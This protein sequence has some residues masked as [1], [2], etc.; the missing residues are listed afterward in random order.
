MD[1]GQRKGQYS[2]AVSAP[3]RFRVPQQLTGTVAARTTLP[4]A[5]PPNPE[6]EFLT[7]DDGT[8]VW[9][10]NSPDERNML[11]AIA[12]VF[13]SKL[14][15]T[16][17]SPGSIAGNK[18]ETVVGIGSAEDETALYCHLTS[19]RAVYL[20][21]AGELSLSDPPA[22]VLFCGPEIER[23]L[24][25]WL[26][27]VPYNNRAP[28][29]IWGR[30]RSELHRQVLS[31]SCAAALNGPSPTSYVE[32]VQSEHM[33]ANRSIQAMKERL[34][35][36]A[37]VLS[38]HG[39]SEGVSLPL[40]GGSALCR[41]PNLGRPSNSERGPECA[42]TGFCKA[43]KT[44]V[45]DASAAGALISPHVIAARILVNTGCHGAFVGSSYIDSAWSIF[46]D[47]VTNPTVGAVLAVPEL[48]LALLDPLRQELITALRGG[49]PV[50]VALAHF[51]DNPTVREIGFRFLLFGDPQVRASPPSG[52]PVVIRRD[53]ASRQ[54]RQL[55]VRVLP[56]ESCDSASALEVLRRIALTIKLETRE[57]GSETSRAL[58]AHLVELEEEENMGLAIRGEIG[59]RV[60]AGV[61][62]HLATTKVRLFEAW[63]TGATLVRQAPDLV[64][65]PHCGWRNRPKIVMTWEEK[66]EFRIC[67]YCSD[68]EDIQL[69]RKV[70]FSFALPEIVC[71]PLER[72]DAWAAAVYIVRSIPKHTRIIPWPS[73]MDGGPAAS[74][75]IDARISPAGPVRV[76]VVWMDGLE[77]SSGCI[78]TV[79]VDAQT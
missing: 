69:P 35:A 25:Q 18:A 1:S 8:P 78:P 6:V 56:K 50:G 44:P 11:S 27:L 13:G 65:C 24:A 12:R 5:T 43:L 31:A 74:L 37:G 23:D 30:D 41:W 21:S 2:D 26:S 77:I 29:L 68:V 46:P 32:I 19:R 48:S 15:D 33:G 79:G 49:E 52:N 73:A 10:V 40:A 16:S 34:G 76:Y 62:A 38:I 66:R 61:L 36:G 45:R 4:I 47:I 54:T 20:T 75:S 63:E 71:T 7:A 72:S 17:A 70:N 64:P 42:Y 3:V 53:T 28:G 39:H 57:E 14:A 67:A 59:S 55:K 51:E 9:P 22:V 58:L 60:R